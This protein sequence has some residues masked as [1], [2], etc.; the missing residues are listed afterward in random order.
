MTSRGKSRG[1]NW[2]K[3]PVKCELCGREG[4]RDNIEGHIDR[5]HPGKG[6]KVI[7]IKPKDVPDISHAFKKLS[8]KSEVPT[9]EHPQQPDHDKVVDG[10]VTED[11]IM[12]DVEN[13]SEKRKYPDRDEEEC[14]KFKK[15]EEDLDEKLRKIKESILSEV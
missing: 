10:T 2:S 7:V 13:N 15:V 1:W 6:I 5:D 9:E 12:D 3:Q 14:S 4:R 11:C 8:K